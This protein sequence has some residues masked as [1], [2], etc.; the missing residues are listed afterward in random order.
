VVLG[1]EHGRGARLEDHPGARGAAGVGAFS[2]WQG[3]HN[4]KVIQV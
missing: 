1:N 3:A 2:Y 4:W